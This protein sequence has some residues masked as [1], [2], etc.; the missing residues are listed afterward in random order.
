MLNVQFSEIKYIYIVLWLLIAVTFCFV[1]L[2]KD[3][4]PLNSKLILPF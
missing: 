1:K 4:Y 2:E 3:T